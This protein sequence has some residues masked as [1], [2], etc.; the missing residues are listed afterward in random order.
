M[1]MHTHLPVPVRNRIRGGFR[2]GTWDPQGGVFSR[3]KIRNCL[4]LLFLLLPAAASLACT[5]AVLS[6]PPMPFYYAEQLRTPSEFMPPQEER[7]AGCGSRV[8]V[9]Q[10]QPVPGVVVIIIGVSDFERITQLVEDLLQPLKD[11]NDNAK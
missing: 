8:R 5:K 2:A 10:T 4:G 3:A 1:C 11:R 9:S 7:Q 6:P